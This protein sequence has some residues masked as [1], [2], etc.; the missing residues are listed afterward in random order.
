MTEEKTVVKKTSIPGLLVIERPVFR[1][2]RGLFHEIFRSNE[3]EEA[4]GTKFNPVQWSHSRSLPKV[5]R[6]IHTEDWNKHVYPVTGK[7]FAAICDLRPE[8]PTFGK[9][10]T[11]EFDADDPNSTQKAL[12]IPKGGIGNSICVVGDKPV[13]YVYLVDEYWDNAKAKGIIW[14][15]PD[16]AIKWPIAD[17]IVSERDQKNPTVREMFPD[18]FKK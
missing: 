11:F 14:N 13:E 17:P 8:S 16:L 4:I 18:K 15:D 9:V 5:I 12:F 2:D 7:M 1:D 10:E 6:A 3:L